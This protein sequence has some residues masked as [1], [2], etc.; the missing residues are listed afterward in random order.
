MAVSRWIFSFLLFSARLN[1]EF[2]LHQ[3]L[4]AELQRGPAAVKLTQSLPGA[5]SSTCAS[6]CSE[7]MGEA[8][9]PSLTLDEVKICPLS[10]QQD[11]TPVQEPPFNSGQHCPQLFSGTGDPYLVRKVPL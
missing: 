4:C 9:R 6:L 2:Q 8:T 5:V 3:D 7:G 10:S 11:Q 1:S